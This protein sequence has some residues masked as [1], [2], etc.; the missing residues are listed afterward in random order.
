MHGVVVERLGCM[1]GALFAKV[2]GAWMGAEACPL[3]WYKFDI[4]GC[5]PPK[6]D[7]NYDRRSA[8]VWAH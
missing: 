5:K 8:R 7:N 6:A 2:G 4:E 1:L 3:A